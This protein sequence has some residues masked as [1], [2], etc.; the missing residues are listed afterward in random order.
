LAGLDVADLRFERRGVVAHVRRSKTDPEGD[1][2]ELG[3]HRAGQAELCPVRAL[4]AW[5]KARGAW[6]GPV[7]CAID[8]NHPDGEL[9]RERL[10]PD[11]ISQVVKRAA[12]AAGL[13]PRRIGGHSL[14]AGCATAAGAAGASDIAIMRRTGHRSLAMVGRYIR[15]ASV[16]AL[17]PLREALA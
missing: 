14:R 6:A 2:R 5:L 3:V 9:R 8:P 10:H 15:P 4:R 11:A 1:G 13:D 16:F 7:F 17:D 12:A